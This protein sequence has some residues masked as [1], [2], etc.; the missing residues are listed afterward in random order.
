MGGFGYKKLPTNSKYCG[1]SLNKKNHVN[2]NSLLKIDNKSARFPLLHVIIFWAMVI[3]Y[4]WNCME[5]DGS[6]KLCTNV[7]QKVPNSFK[8]AAVEN[9]NYLSVVC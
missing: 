2:C 9:S 1:W 3:K 5:D 7:L 8:C 4:G 6:L